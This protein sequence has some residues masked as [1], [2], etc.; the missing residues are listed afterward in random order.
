MTAAT[1]EPTGIQ[2]GRA[3]LYLRV[4]TPGQ[5]RTDYDP[6]GISLP[7]Q[8]KACQRKAE[9]L[10]LAVV[11]EYVEAGVSGRGTE[12]RLEFQKMLAR[13]KTAKDVDHVIVHKLSRLAR[14]RID[15][16]LVMDQ[17]NR[18]HVTLVS[19]TEP[20]DNTPEGQFMQGI[21]SAMAQFRSQQD[22]EDVAYKMGEKAKRGGTLG[23]APIGY[24]NVREKVDG[25]EVRAVAV[26]AGLA[27]FVRTA[28]EM[29]RDGKTIQAI[30]DELGARGFLRPAM[31]NHPAA[32]LTDGAMG[33]LLRNPYY[34]G[35]VRYKGEL[36]PGRQPALVDRELFDQVQ[37]ALSERGPGSPRHRIHDHLLK[38]MLWCGEC[39]DRGIE[40]R[41]ILNKS[42]GKAGGVFWHY[43][44]NG[45]TFATDR[46]EHAP[47]IQTGMIER[48]VA[49]YYRQVGFSKAF[50]D[51]MG[52]MIE[53][54]IGELRESDHIARAEAEQQ[55][56]KLKSQEERLVQLVMDGAAE[57]DTVREQLNRLRLG[58]AEA[59]RQLDSIA[60]D[61]ARGAANIREILRFMQNPAAWYNHPL[62]SDESR[63]RLN[64]AI[65][66]K[67]YVDCEREERKTSVSAAA[68]TEDIQQLKDMET[69]FDRTGRL[70]DLEREPPLEMRA[71]GENTPGDAIRNDSTDRPRAAVSA[72]ATEAGRA[73]T[74]DA[75]TRNSPIGF[76]EKPSRNIKPAENQDP[77]SPETLRSG[78]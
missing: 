71:R 64:A 4:S 63:K 15:E 67:I 32:P 46:H 50:T 21:L 20:I 39:H 10:G 77:D 53:Q 36:Y 69:R 37:T 65:F 8:R 17:F 2:A 45:R 26:D 11:G 75:F 12:H 5:V 18:R 9:Q 16:A 62:A 29:Y 25:H 27:P 58:R 60:E 28:F 6:E 55:A 14:N 22:G 40:R 47:Y 54:T 42:R 78:L 76:R 70:D 57:N 38:G 51:A 66:A 49:R 33:K 74:S 72:R 30:C 61:A 7:A 13:I 41:M 34:L 35:Y 52:Q 68:Y 43:F 24:L 31:R 19:A 44:C 1:N 48:A 73:D 56:A 59:E 3:V 23:K